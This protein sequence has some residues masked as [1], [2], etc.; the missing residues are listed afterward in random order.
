MTSGTVFDIG[1]QRYTDRREGR[2]RSRRAMFKD[3]VVTIKLAKAARAK[4]TTIPV[5]AAA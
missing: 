5:K 4:G 2:D 3:G 1:Y